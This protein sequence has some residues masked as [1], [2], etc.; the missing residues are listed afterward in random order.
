MKQKV[1]RSCR[2]AM[3]AMLLPALL[4]N[5]PALAQAIAGDNTSTLTLAVFM[6]G[7]TPNGTNAFAESLDGRPFITAVELA[8]ELVNNRTDILP[9]YTL[10]FTA[11]DSQVYVS[12][13]LH[14]HRL[15]GSYPTFIHQRPAM[16][17]N[18]SCM[19]ILRV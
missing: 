1:D 18:H 6:S 16:Q 3:L 8:L 15:R 12:V 9:G 5:V 13:S 14:H 7:I 17:L 11:N 4:Q 19:I 2:L 10:D